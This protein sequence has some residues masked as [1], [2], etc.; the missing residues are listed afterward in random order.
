MNQIKLAPLTLRSSF[1]KTW[2][3]GV[4]TV[5]SL[6]WLLAIWCSSP[7]CFAQNGALPSTFRWMSTDPLA[8]PQNGSLAMKD[9][10]CVHYN[11]K[12]IVYFTTV[13]SAGSWGGGMMT[14]TNWSDMATAQQ[15]QMPI[16]TVAPT[17]F[18]FAPKNIWVLTFQ[19]GAQYLTSTDPTNP[20][21]WSAPQPLYQGNSLDTT[22]ICDSTNAYLFYAYDD[23]TIHRASMPIGSFPGTFTNSS[24]IMTDTAANLFEAV[25]VYTVQGATPQYLMIV[26]AEGAAGRYFR[27]FTATNLGGSW[28][29]LAA[30]ESNPFAG[31]N[32]VTFPDGNIWT[33]DISHGDIV[34]NNPDQTQTIDPS[35]LQFLYQ[36]WTYTSGLTNYTQIP[37][38]PGVLTLIQPSD[39]MQIYSGRFDNGWGDGWS[40]MTRYPTNN[41]VY[42]SN[43]VFVASNSMA[44]VPSVPYVVWLLKPYTT[45]DATLYTNL[46]FWINGGAT[47]GQNISVYGELNGSSS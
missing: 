25:Q 4:F 22:V 37:W 3:K 33:S 8:S 39:D 27:S 17:L 42:T 24:V 29:P 6:L 20:N 28:T 38:R 9:F 44:L 21:G 10:T 47:G 45:V 7:V 30:T 15:Y 5:A 16:G 31:K 34:R 12:Y 43:L 19:W 26:E 18:Y 35:N 14:F 2:G 46:T 23:G 41:P 13:D 1:A 11:G 40:W 32:N 36:G